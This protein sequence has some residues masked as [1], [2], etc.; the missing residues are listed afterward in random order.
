[1]KNI[2][3][4][5]G[6]ISSEHDVSVITGVLTL[7][8]IDKTLYNPIPVYVTKNGEWL[9]GE[10]L[11]DVAFYKKNDFSKLKRVTLLSG[12]NTLYIKGRKLKKVGD[13]F[14]AVNCQH[15]L[16]GEDGTLAGLLK[17]HNIPLVGSPLFSSSLSIDKGFTKAVLKGLNVECLPCLTVYKG[18]FIKDNQNEILSIE[19]EI[20]YPIIIK[21]ANLGSSIGVS[22]AKDKS[23]LVSGLNVAFLYD[24][25]VIIEKY[26]ENFKEYNCA[27]YQDKSGYVVSKVERPLSLDKIL[28]FKDKYECY[29][30]SLDREFPAKISKELTEKIQQTTKLVYKACEFSGI[31][32]I[33]YLYYENKLYLN[34]INSIPGSL[35]Y[36]L[37]TDTLKGFTEILNLLISFSV[38][39]HNKFK[40]RKFT[41]QSGV[42]SINGAKSGK[43]KTFDK[44][45]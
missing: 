40:A 21:P 37:F 27:C 29:T 4:F 20:S 2:V 31:V 36:Y 13:I 25:K 3:V 12:E 22:V 10:E 9:Y 19:K 43:A 18:D 16:N 45:D 23:E 6:G 5:F 17:L 42:L 26:L 15:G 14:C 30:G 33:D 34:E 41:Y 35:S 7:N 24:D 28:S 32:R 11:F 44:N 1:M 8:S 38:E 39:S